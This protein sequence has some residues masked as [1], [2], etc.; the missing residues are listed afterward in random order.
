MDLGFSA[1]ITVWLTVASAFTCNGP[2]PWNLTAIL[3]PVGP[4]ASLLASVLHP[5]PSPRCLQVGGSEVGN[6]AVE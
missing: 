6:E 1:E 5:G 2:A 3:L 4:L